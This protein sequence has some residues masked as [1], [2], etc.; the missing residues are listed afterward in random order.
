MTA[1]VSPPPSSTPSC[2][3]VSGEA[4]PAVFIQS[5]VFSPDVPIKIDYNGKHFNFGNGA[6]NA[7]FMGLASFSDMQLILKSVKKRNF[8][9]YDKILTYVSNEWYTDITQRQ[10]QTIACALG[11]LQSISKLLT[12][13]CALV[14]E[15][16]ESYR[17]D[18]QIVRG[19]QKGTKSFG[20]NA[21]SALIELTTRIISVVQ[22]AAVLTYN[23][24]SPT[25]RQ[26]NMLAISQQPFD[27]RE[28]V[29]NAYMVMANGIN[30]TARSLVDATRTDTG[31]DKGV[32]RMVGEVLR[33]IPPAMVRPI[34]DVTTAT[35]TVLNGVKYQLQ[36]EARQ[37]D[38]DKWKPVHNGRL[39]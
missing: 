34:I 3:P 6:L 29:H 13:I 26:P 36:P 1:L 38:L 24:V 23:V 18:G 14:R 17:K 37:A 9:G 20:T 30:D 12:G 4:P 21:A 35:T 5:F 16:V 31:G 11:P 22:G 8:R 39:N 2:A 10:L 27:V 7:I 33:Q 28:G 25:A 19:F 32:T 15:P